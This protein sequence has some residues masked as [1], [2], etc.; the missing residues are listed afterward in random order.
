M[1]LL[2]R[3]PQAG[4]DAGLRPGLPDTVDQVRPAGAAQEGRPGAPRA[5]APA[6]RN[7]G[8][9]LRGRRHG[10]GRPQ[11]LL[12]PAGQA[13]GLRPA[14]AAEAAQ[15]QR[16]AVVAVGRLRGADDGAG[17]A[18]RLPAAR[19]AGARRRAAAGRAGTRRPTAAAR[20]RGAPGRPTGE[21]RIMNLFVADPHWG[22]WIL[23]YF[24]LGGIA[25]GAY[26]A[27]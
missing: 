14:V 4:A 16:A 27:A 12:P 18:L 3:P 21:D 5:A 22:H 13:R 20:L 24:Y 19:A 23:L 17:D 7:A 2:L 6:G 11:L 15:P 8:P 25:A 9:P 26:F 10:A 1:H